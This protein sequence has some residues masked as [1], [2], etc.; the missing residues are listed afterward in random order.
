M[1]QKEQHLITPFG[2]M[3]SILVNAL[4]SLFSS[5]VSQEKGPASFIWLISIIIAP[6]AQA[7]GC[8]EPFRRPSYV[9]RS[10]FCSAGELIE[11]QY[12]LGSMIRCEDME[13]DH[14][15]SLR[16]AWESGVCGADLSRLANDPANLR[17]TF[18]R[19]NRSKGRMSAFEFAERLNV[20][21]R[22]GVIRDATTVA[23]K[24]KILSRQDIVALRISSLIQ[25]YRTITVSPSQLAKI[26]SVSSQ[27]INGRMA[28]FIGK[29]V[30][31]TASA[32]GATVTAIK[33]A[34]WAFD[35]A[36]LPSSGADQEELQS[37]FNNIS[38]EWSVTPPSGN[39]AVVPYQIDDQLFFDLLF[40]YV[41]QVN[42]VEFLVSDCTG[43]RKLGHLFYGNITLTFNYF[44]L[45]LGVDWTADIFEEQSLSWRLYREFLNGFTRRDTI[46]VAGDPIAAAQVEA[47][48][49][50][51]ENQDQSQYLCSAILWDE[52]GKLHQ[53]TGEVIT[54]ANI[55]FLRHP[56]FAEFQK[57]SAERVL[58][59]QVM[60]QMNPNFER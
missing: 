4:H 1:N 32:L 20:R 7:F 27:M 8:D 40:D 17:V 44:E 54:D 9:S 41:Y 42:L 31:G 46:D 38:Q 36:L 10:T 28:Y 24:Y 5:R 51:D 60:L 21:E 35:N 45:L 52:I 15:V 13:I 2:F 59:L 43:S 29:R 39:L 30:I 58:N 48:S 6:Q 18:W 49:V 3:I 23:Q 47:H 14:L 19:T 26:G 53:I 22:D 37:V 57:F 34:E 55:R 12:N 50:I 25:R 33:V 11:D 16:E 56:N